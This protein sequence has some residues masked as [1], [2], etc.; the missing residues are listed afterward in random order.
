MEPKS[1]PDVIEAMGELR[2]EVVSLAERLDKIAAL[3]E[4]L[5]S[6]VGLDSDVIAATKTEVMG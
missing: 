4:A 2:A 1:L 6:R 5:A 3:T